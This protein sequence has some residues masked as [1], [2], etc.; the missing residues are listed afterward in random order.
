MRLFT[1]ARH[2]TTIARMALLAYALSLGL[3]IAA[4]LVNTPALQLIC[5]S[6]G[7]KLVAEPGQDNPTPQASLDCPLC[8]AGLALPPPDLGWQAVAPAGTTPLLAL[9]SPQHDAAP[10]AP[11]QARAPPSF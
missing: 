9:A 7:V 8:L 10:A 5:T 3:A 2:L 4:P 6:A 1:T 11:W